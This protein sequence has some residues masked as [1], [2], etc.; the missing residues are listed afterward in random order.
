MASSSLPAGCRDA[1]RSAS[2][3]A[4][5][6]EAG[7]ARQAASTFTL[8]R[9]H[10][11]SPRTSAST[12]QPGAGPRSARSRLLGCPASD[13]AALGEY[14]IVSLLSLFI[15][16]WEKSVCSCL[17]APS[18]PGVARRPRARISSRRS[19]LEQ[20]RSPISPRLPCAGTRLLRRRSRRCSLQFFNETRSCQTIFCSIA[21][22][23]IYFRKPRTSNCGF[24]QGRHE[25]SPR[26]CDPA[27]GR[28]RKRAEGTRAR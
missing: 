22:R 26:A 14:L 3:R 28:R 10:A 6:S 13:S 18:P 24:S 1:G 15:S 27:R 16:A 21:Y 9:S 25:R 7:A 23:N 5:A 17:L 11:V 12:G 4:G 8:A 2:M 19:R 20:E